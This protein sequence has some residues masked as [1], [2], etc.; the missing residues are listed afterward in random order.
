M[1]AVGQA[2]AKWLLQFTN[3]NYQ[4]KDGNGRPWGDGTAMAERANEG[5]VPWDEGCLVKAMI[6][7]Y[8]AMGAIRDT[9]ERAIVEAETPA[10]KQLP[11]GQRGHVY[12]TGLQFNAQRDLS[13]TN[14]PWKEGETVT[15]DQSALGLVLRMLGVGIGVR[16]L[17]W[18]PNS[19][20]DLT[21][22]RYI[23]A[24]HW[25]VATAV[26]KYNATL[27]GLNPSARG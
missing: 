17:L 18:M 12:I 27:E 9:F 25:N 3:S 6:G 14:T 20:E 2:E 22:T 15:A 13:R 19:F 10:M 24:E 1:P 7:G 26:Q 4:A 21:G 23:A 16:L 5:K 11:F 8:A